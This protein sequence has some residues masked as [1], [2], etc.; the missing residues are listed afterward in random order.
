[1]PFPFQIQR[2]ARLFQKRLGI[3]GHI[4]LTLL[5]D[6]TPTIEL[7]EPSDAENHFLRQ[8]SLMAARGGAGAV[9]G[10]FSRVALLNDERSGALVVLEQLQMS[11]ANNAQ[12][13]LTPGVAG[14]TGNN[15]PRDG[16]I[17]NPAIAGGSFRA[18]A[19]QVIASTGVAA[20]IT[21]ANAPILV[22]GSFERQW[23]IPPGQQLLVENLVANQACEVT[24]YWR[25]VPL[26]PQELTS[27]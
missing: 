24:F 18:A 22:P 26:A 20:L 9:A 19:V 12:M 15:P 13:V 16:R 25:E 10:Q 17:V 8:E 4:P 21:L 14:A 2:L 3:L 5:E 1:M 23:V 27:G 7:W 6:V 11:S